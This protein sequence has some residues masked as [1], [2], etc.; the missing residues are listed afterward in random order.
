[1]SVKIENLPLL[2]DFLCFRSL[3]HQF[4]AFVANIDGGDVGCG[5]FVFA[6]FNIFD[7]VNQD[8]ESPVINELV[9]HYPIW[10]MFLLSNP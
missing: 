2:T 8:V 1:M 6:N 3:R 7:V 9:Q 5:R 4:I 10:D